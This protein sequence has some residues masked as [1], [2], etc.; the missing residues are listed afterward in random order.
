[1]KV[2]IYGQVGIEEMIIPSVEIEYADTGNTDTLTITLK[3]G[4]PIPYDL[5]IATTNKFANMSVDLW[6]KYGRDVPDAINIVLPKSNFWI[7]VRE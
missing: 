2:N 5:L 6:P 1:M 3:R 7:E 4:V